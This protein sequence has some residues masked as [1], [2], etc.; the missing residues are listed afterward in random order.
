MPLPAQCLPFIGTESRRERVRENK[1]E[2]GGRRRRR[3][4]E[5][6]I[7]DSFVLGDMRMPEKEGTIVPE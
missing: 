5:R 7:R 2:E 1:R 4:R 6:K 3:R